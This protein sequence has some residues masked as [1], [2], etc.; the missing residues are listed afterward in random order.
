ML[1][2][3]CDYHPGFQQ[4]AFV[5][6]ETGELQERRLQHREEA[7]KFYRDLAAQGMKVRVGMEA[8]GH[9]RWFERLLA[10]LN[11]ELWMG[12]AAEIHRKRERK[13]KTDRQ[14]AQHILRL[15]LKDDFPRIWVPSWENRDL[16]QLLW[17]RHRMVQARTRMM[18][19]LQAVALNEGLRY[20]K[21]LWRDAGRKQLEA[22]RLAPWASRRRHDLLEL[23][24]RLNPTIAELTQAIERE[25][26]KCPEARRLQTHPGVGPLTALAFVLIIGK[27]DRFQWGKQIASYLGLVPLEDSSGNRRRLGHITKQGN[28]LLRFLLVEAAQVTARSL[29]EWRSKYVHLTMRRGRKIATPS[30]AE[31][32]AAIVNEDPPAISQAVQMA[33]PG[34]QKIVNRCL[35]KN[36]ELRFQHASDLAFALEALSDDGRTATSS[37]R[38]STASSSKPV[39]LAAVVSLVV[40]AALLFW[41][42]RPPAVP[43]VEAITQLT[44]DGNTKGV[45]NSLQTD[46]PR[47]YFNEGRWGSLEIKQV[48]VTGGPVAAIPTPL[49]DA[50]PVGI[51]PDGSFLLVL[52]GGAGP[53]PKPAWELPLPFGEQVVVARGVQPND[54]RRSQAEDGEHRQQGNENQGV[55]R[56]RQKMT[57]NRANHRPFPSTWYFGA[58]GIHSSCSGVVADPRH[59]EESQSSR[60]RSL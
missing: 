50:Q 16:R 28:S 25:V 4:I 30:S 9:A 39:S 1:I 19:Q 56:E 35:A 8:S 26:E 21:R 37:V 14:D 38:V 44:D 45:H 22:F 23:L 7:E 15:L 20:K 12:D 2:I 52:P 27:A 48:A 31:T 59:A 41:W 49:V 36:P 5:D 54:K 17:H 6:T 13:Q 24:D 11:I 58:M 18:N 10:E 60:S 32:M 55:H 42:T 3:G 34:L 57:K 53:P 33:S 47:I 43:V 40:L 29:P 51:S 46:G